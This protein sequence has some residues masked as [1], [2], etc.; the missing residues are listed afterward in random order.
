MSTDFDF[1]DMIYICH[2][3]INQLVSIQQIYFVVCVYKEG[4]RIK[5]KGICI[6]FGNEF[7]VVVIR[8]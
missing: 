4:R 7:K 2:P 6:S 1:N 3:L 5:R 8:H